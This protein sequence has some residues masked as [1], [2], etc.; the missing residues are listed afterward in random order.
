MNYRFIR[1]WGWWAAVLALALAACGRGGGSGAGESGSGPVRVATTLSVFADFVRQVG[2]E[3]VTVVT[4][5]PAGADPHTY[6]PAPR[7]VQRLTTVRAVFVN[8]AGLEGGLRD[9]IEHNLPRGATL[10]ELSAGLTPITYTPEE[11]GPAD[12]GAGHGPEEG[13]NPHFWLDVKNAQHY[14]R[15]IRDTLVEV[16]PEGR[17]A[18]TANADRYLAELDALDAEIRAKIATIPPE[19]RKLVTF[20]DA[21][22]Y[23]ARAYGLQLVGYV[24]RAPGREPSAQ[25]IKELSAVLRR[26]QVKTVYKEPQLNAKVLERAAA[27]AGVRVDVLYSDALTKDVPTYVAM[28]RRNADALVRGLA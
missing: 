18:Y 21:F 9:L 12:S 7:D 1:R 4:L 16:D 25:E 28:M 17:E 26:E 27:D 14:V 8:G 6:Q 19:R 11:V 3:R 22:P 15:R 24:V 13:V 10:V 23:F 5:V 20:H 2:G